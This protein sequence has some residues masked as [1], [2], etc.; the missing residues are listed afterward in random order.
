LVY[1]GALLTRFVD[2]Q[3]LAQVA[4]GGDGPHRRAGQAVH[5]LH[6]AGVIH[7]DLNAHNILDDGARA[8]VIDLDRSRV[9]NRLTSFQRARS[10]LRLRRSYAKLG[11]PME[12]FD[13]FLE[14]YGPITF[15]ALLRALYAARQTLA[16]RA[17]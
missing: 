1:R 10:V 3:P 12:R 8:W 15:P 5:A 6:E 17:R 4:A 2:A 16:G 13:A 11:I 7:A 14:G 9:V